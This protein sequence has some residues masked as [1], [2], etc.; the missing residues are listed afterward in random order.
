MADIRG[1]A[2][3]VYVLEGSDYE[4][5]EGQTDA[6][7]NGGTDTVDTT[8]KDSGGWGSLL[9]TTLNGE[10]TLAGN[11]RTTRPRLQLFRT[12][13]RNFSTVGVKIVFDIGDTPGDGYVGN[14]RVS[15]FQV[16]APT[17]D[18][19]KYNITLSPDE[20]GLTELS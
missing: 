4:L 3:L 10:I 13:W 6:T 15:Q 5:V 17:K 12:A 9:P 2:C 7:F 1:N 8:A 20:S 14:M 19:V 11:M 18:V 16:T